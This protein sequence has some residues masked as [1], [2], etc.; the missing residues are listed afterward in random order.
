MSKFPLCSTDDLLSLPFERVQIITAN[1]RLAVFIKELIIQNLQRKVVA[2]PAITPYKAWL[3]LLAQQRRFV[4]TEVALPLEEFGQQW[5]WRQAIEQVEH[6]L[7]LLSVAQAAANASQAHRQ[8]SEWS[9]Q[10][11]EEERS[12]EYE[13]FLQWR[14]IYQVKRDALGAWDTPQIIQA[15]LEAIQDGRLKVPEHILVCGFYS[16]SPQQ[17]DL[18]QALQDRGC[19]VRELRLP[20]QHAISVQ[21][22]TAS[23]K[24]H[25]LESAVNWAKQMLQDYP[26]KRVAIVC[27]DL[28][29]E[30]A[31]VRRVLERHLTA[32]NL[33]YHVAV[34]RPLNE[35]SLVRSLM[36]WLEL[37]ASMQKPR[38]S[39][40][41]LGK[42][43]NNA[44]FGATNAELAR[45]TQLDVE[46][47]NG[48]AVSLTSTQIIERLNAKSET[49]DTEADT[50]A[51]NFAQKFETVYKALPSKN[52]GCSD[53]AQFIRDFLTTLGFPGPQTLSSENYQVCHAFER[54]VKNLAALDEVLGEL[55]LE[56][57]V[58][59][60]QQL[61]S[62]TMF[63]AKRDTDARLDVVG[64]YEVE[65]GQ[66]DAA[67]VV[68]LHDDALPSLAK[69][70]PFIPVNSQ[71]R[72]Q[73][74]H[75]T[76]ESEMQ[77]ATQIF[78]SILHSVP[79][80]I[81]SWP[82]ES[83]GQIMRPSSFVAHLAVTEL[84]ELPS[85]VARAVLLE[86]IDDSQGLPI[87]KDSITGQTEPF[88]GGYTALERQS[89]NPLWAYA[90]SRLGL[91][92]L[93]NYP[94]YELNPLNRGK[95]YHKALELIWIGLKDSTRL[96]H[97]SDADLQHLIEQ[98]VQLAAINELKMLSS[99]SLLELEKN[100]AQDILWLLLNDEKRREDFTVEQIE[101]RVFLE[102]KGLKF[103]FVID[104]VDRLENGS[105]VYLDYKT[106]NV[107]SHSEMQRR[108]FD[109]D[110][111]IDIQLP[112]Y[113]SS[114]GLAAA[115][116]ISAVSYV[117]LKR[118]EM[119]Y[120]GVGVDSLG[121]DSKAI[122]EFTEQE[123]YSIVQIWQDKIAVLID[124]FAQGVA[125]NRYENFK[126]ME[127][128]KVMPFLRCHQTEEGAGDE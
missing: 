94:K 71:R 110:C 32:A 2:L 112:L 120:K 8:L 63:Q 56:Q 9:I 70:N 33:T 24:T 81:L 16:L 3:D 101:K 127:Y 50:K 103:N 20:K 67:W 53:W 4:S 115:E 76:P 15:S 85:A 113:A 105:V 1:N 34:G 40:S 5:L 6:E 39:I 19:S 90:S 84:P 45:L 96:K 89:R 10:V 83:E 59:V 55:S 80:L 125:T 121:L 88:F 49:Q 7:P 100:R 86:T 122:K 78:D 106:G 58:S 98:S 104:R 62:R 91:D 111:P 107:T 47:R 114:L 37:L 41:L 93:K 60:L 61:L 65:G 27:P 31:Y 68:G 14:E 35:W 22:Y 124:D 42:A 77:W 99:S 26:E 57:L 29:A 11:R 38:T 64:L 12:Q 69:P 97:I 44:C 25:E 92:E 79:E 108:W 18:L 87:Q 117:G 51:A 116:Q 72:A 46:L 36:S 13:R 17:S 30:V 82:Q 95:F 74:L 109:R 48:E 75:A 123:W 102:A 54:V 126:D 128:C 21:V 28:Q 23:D 52:L 43:L 118:G 66:W 73:V 119:G